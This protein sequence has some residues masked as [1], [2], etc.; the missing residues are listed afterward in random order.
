MDEHRTRSARGVRVSVFG[1]MVNAS[2]A[3]IKL[4]AGIVGHCYA[5]IA[6]AVESMADIFSSIVVW[7]GMTIAAQPPDE[8][9]PYG[10]GKAEQLAAL[11][12]AMMLFGAGI[13]IA[14]QAVREII[15]PHHAP[16]SHNCIIS[17]IVHQ[18]SFEFVG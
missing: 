8:D 2:L 12:V 13:G 4:L 15:T 10:H 18:S 5:L 1:L 11:I 17:F 6:D 16:A 9:H 14:I 7:R 3:I